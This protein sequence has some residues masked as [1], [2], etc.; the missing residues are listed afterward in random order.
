MDEALH[1]AYL[2]TDYRV[3]LARGG[4][5]AIHI[6][7]PLPSA[8]KELAGENPWGF[9][10]AWNPRSEPTPRSQ[11]KAA[12]RALFEALRAIPET[13]A[14]RPGL[15]VARTGQWAEPSLWVVGL[16]IAALDPLAAHF[17]QFGYVHGQGASPAKL[18]LMSLV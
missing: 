10:T 16:G 7:K 3:R 4:W 14:I 1:A 8:L 9:I 17:G 2:A 13:V 11:N 12:Q 6:D 18:R 5:A 15:G